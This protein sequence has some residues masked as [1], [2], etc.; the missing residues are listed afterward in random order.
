MFPERDEFQWPE[1]PEDLFADPS[2]DLPAW[3]KQLMPDPSASSAA[4]RIIDGD[5]YLRDL[6][7]DVVT[8]HPSDWVV[9]TPH[10]FIVQTDAVHAATFDG[11]PK[12]TPELSSE[13]V[14]PAIDSAS[15]LH[16]SANSATASVE[17][18]DAPAAA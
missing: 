4:L 15:K 9:R 16:A 5:G 3:L 14:D 12:S 11:S 13:P 7:G 1:P 17:G 18:D 2:P 8:I 10:G 6:S